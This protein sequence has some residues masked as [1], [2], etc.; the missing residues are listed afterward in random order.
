[1]FKEI[2]TKLKFFVRKQE[3]IKN[4]IADFFLKN[5]RENLELKLI[6]NKVENTMHQIRYS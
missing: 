6:R 2:Q 4:D 1:M 5:Q 3:V